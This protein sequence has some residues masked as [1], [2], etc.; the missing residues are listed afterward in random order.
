[1]NVKLI[2]ALETTSK[3]ASFNLDIDLQHAYGYSIVQTVS[4]GAGLTSAT[5]LQASVDGVT[6]VDFGSSTNT[7]TDGSY[8]WN[9]AD[10]MY[11]HLRIVTTIS[12]GSAN[13]QVRVNVKGV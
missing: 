11:R 13:Y 12:A 5:K 7:S 6:F 8:L 2:K 1:M 4:G 10:A 3:S 9:V